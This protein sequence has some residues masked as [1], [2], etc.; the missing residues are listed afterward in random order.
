MCKPKALGSLEIMETNLM[1]IFMMANWIWKMYSGE[2]GLWV[3][4]LRAKYIQ[5]KIFWSIHISPEI[6]FLE[7]G[8]ID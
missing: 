4:L 6:S 8:P 2:Q 3:E 7:L 1:N 5:I